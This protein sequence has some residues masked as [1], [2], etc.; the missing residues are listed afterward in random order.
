SASILSLAT[1]S[2]V[3]TLFPYTTLF[4]SVLAQTVTQ[5][6]CDAIKQGVTAGHDDH[7]FTAKVVF[8]DADRLLQVATDGEPFHFDFRHQL[9][10]VFGAEDQVGRRDDLTSSR[11]EAA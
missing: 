9:E 10:G 11:C 6:A 4:R 2:A 8:Q 1:A 5:I 3:S 7:A